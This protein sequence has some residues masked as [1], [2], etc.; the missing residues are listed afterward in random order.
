MRVPVFAMTIAKGG[1]GFTKSTDEGLLVL[2]PGEQGS[3]NIQHFSM[4]ELTQELSREQF[5][6]PVVDAN[7]LKGRYDSHI[8]M[9]TIAA[10][11]PNDLMAFESALIKSMQE[12]VAPKIER[13]KEE[14]DVQVIDHAVKTPTEH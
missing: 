14:V 11:N 9:S 5:D 10:A 1:S 8:D 3:L 12:P 13:R 6:R 7:G 2:G 4:R